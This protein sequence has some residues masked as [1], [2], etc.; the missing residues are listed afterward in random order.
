ME[1]V[2]DQPT[3]DELIRRID[4]LNENNQGGWGKMNLYQAVKHC[5]MRDE[6]MQSDKEISPSL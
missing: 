4:A 2:F 6:W 5:A 1:T 3:R